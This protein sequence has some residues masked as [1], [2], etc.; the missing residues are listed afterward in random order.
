M[1]ERPVFQSIHQAANGEGVKAF[2]ILRFKK[3]LVCDIK[4][5]S[6]VVHKGA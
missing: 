2:S 1:D 3:R 6:N 5:M 4:K